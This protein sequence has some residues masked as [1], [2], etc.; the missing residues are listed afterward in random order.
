MRVRL[1]LSAQQPS[2]VDDRS[3]GAVEMSVESVVESEW[4]RALGDENKN[5]KEVEGG[6][7]QLG[8][9]RGT[10]APSSFVADM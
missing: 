3:F 5:F 8:A 9:P 10:Y 2:Q 6:Y 4:R 7:F 1:I